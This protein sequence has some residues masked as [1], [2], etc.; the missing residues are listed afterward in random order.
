M[1]YLRR[2]LWFIAS[3]LVI[4]TVV[5]ALL[6]ITF[7]LAMNT[8]NVYVLLSDGMKMRASVIMTREDADELNNFFVA[9]FLDKDQALAIAFSDNS[10]Y[11]DY[12]I[13]GFN[14]NVS[15]EW[16][17]SWPW[18]DTAQA[19][20]T[21]RVPKIFGNV[22]S[23]KNSLVTEGKLSANPPG[24]ISGKYSVTLVR[25]NGQWKIA[26]LNQISAIIENTPEPTP[27]PTPTS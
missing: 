11:I 7:Y 22:V 21:E 23:D 3:R 26:G 8:A 20:I 10:P 25:I 19:V 6:I 1:K 9:D 15:M 13:T 18:E 2:L 4:F 17:W 12:K 24:W 5:A 27:S 14:H 16:M